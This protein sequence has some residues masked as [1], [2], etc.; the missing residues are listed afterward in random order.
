[1]KIDQL[2]TTLSVLS[3]VTGIRMEDATVQIGDFNFTIGHL[4]NGVPA[5]VGIP[6]KT[7]ASKNR[8]SKPSRSTKRIKRKVSSVPSASGSTGKVGKPVGKAGLHRRQLIMNALEGSAGPMA[9]ASCVQAVMPGMEKFIVSVGG[10]WNDTVSTTQNQLI[11]YDLNKMVERG[12][13]SKNGGGRL[14]TFSVKA[15]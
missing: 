12:I 4:I 11:R 5:A 1:M 7:K 14:T 8:V 13:L 3:R 10:K 15:A 9:L 6:V 2:N